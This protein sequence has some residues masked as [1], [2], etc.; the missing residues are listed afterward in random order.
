MAV[1]L[2]ISPT[3]F[4]GFARFARQWRSVPSRIEICPECGRE[5]PEA[6]DIPSILVP[7]PPRPPSCPNCNSPLQQAPVREDTSD[8]SGTP[9]RVVMTD[10]GD[11]WVINAY[12]PRLQAIETWVF[13]SVWLAV[14]IFIWSR[15][16]NGGGIFINLW[17]TAF[18]ALL[19]LKAAS[20]PGADTLSLDPRIQYMCLAAS[21]HWG[22]A[23]FQPQIPRG[24]TASDTVRPS[25]HQ[26]EERCN[27]RRT[28][29]LLRRGAFRRAATVSR[30]LASLEETFNASTVRGFCGPRHG[31]L[32]AAH[33]VT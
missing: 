17:L 31:L 33:D 9:Q 23:S 5:F 27:T 13:A 4:C 32:E 24:N 7:N 3:I 22:E 2:S 6:P 8:P 26:A 21:G 25:W 19:F 16:F 1:A 15:G 14:M 28:H 18:S 20:E 29:L 12:P 11:S 30:A 10:R